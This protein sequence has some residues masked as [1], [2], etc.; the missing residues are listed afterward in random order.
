MLESEENNKYVNK[1]KTAYKDPK[2]N[3][4]VKMDH[5]IRDIKDGDPEAYDLQKSIAKN[6][7]TNNAIYFSLIFS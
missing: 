5:I 1:F 7:R 4:R 2:N 3:I 6:V